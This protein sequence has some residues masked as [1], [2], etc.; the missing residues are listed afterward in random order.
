MKVAQQEIRS[1]VTVNTIDLGSKKKDD[2][3][4]PTISVPKKR[5]KEVFVK[6]RI[7]NAFYIGSAC[8]ESVMLSP[9]FRA[10]DSSGLLK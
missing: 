9:H 4:D 8:K 2:D 1:T 5:G 7:G 3:N 6:Q 10:L